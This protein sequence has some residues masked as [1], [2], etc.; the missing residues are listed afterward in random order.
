MDRAQPAGDGRQRAG[1]G[2]RA[3]RPRPRRRWPS[4]AR[5]TPPTSRC[6]AGWSATP[7]AWSGRWRGAALLAVAVLV[8]VLRRRGISSLR[9]TAGRPRRWP[10]CRSSWRR[11]PRRGCGR[12]WSLIRPGYAAMLDPWRPGW[13][14]LAAVAARRSRSCCSGTRCCAGGSAP[15]RSPPARWS[16]SPSW[17]PSSP[18]TRPAA[19]TWSAWPALAGAVARHRRGAD[20]QPG[21]AP[22]RRRWS[23]GRSPSW[24]S[25]RPWPCSSRRSACRP[26]PSAASSPTLLVVALLPAFELLF[27]DEEQPRGTGCR[28]PSCPPSPWSSPSPAPPWGCRS[29]GSTPP[30]RCPAS[31]R[32][33]WTATP[34]RP[35]GP[36]RRALR[37]PTR[38]STSG[39]RGTLPVDLPYLAGKEVALGDA[40]AGGPARPAGDDG[41]RRRRRRQAADHRAGH[42][43]AV[44]AS[45]CWP[46]T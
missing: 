41:L 37:A 44:R 31:S 22:G 4:P 6:S 8:L 28:A 39:R 29:T 11:S 21:G 3:R 30:T 14:R 19:P 34:A 9:R 40:P 16:G 46:W 45:V 20:R 33:C 38:R 1:P 36:A 5:T 15:R 7:A 12:C 26:P 23:A 10:C 13:F 24:C 27:P 42:P 32:T 17:P 25:R 18:P 2:P 43:A 35:G